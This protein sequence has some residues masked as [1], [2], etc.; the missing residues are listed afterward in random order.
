MLRD[1]EKGQFGIIG[2]YQV[3]IQSFQSKKQA[4]FGNDPQC[5]AQNSG[6]RKVWST[7]GIKQP[8]HLVRGPG[9]HRL[10]GHHQFWGGQHQLGGQLDDHLIYS[11]RST[12]RTSERVQ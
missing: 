10:G 3:K 7:E 9:H 2:S 6:R 8:L 4:V 11:Q 5:R 12:G 1:K